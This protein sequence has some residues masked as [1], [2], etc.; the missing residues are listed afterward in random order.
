MRCNHAVAISDAKDISHQWHRVETLCAR[1]DISKKST[2]STSTDFQLNTSLLP[3]RSLRHRVRPPSTTH[4]RSVHRAFQATTTTI[5]ALSAETVPCRTQGVST[6][7]QRWLP[8]W[9]AFDGFERLECKRNATHPSTQQWFALR[10]DTFACVS[11]KRE[12]ASQ[13]GDGDCA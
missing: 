11:F 9:N 8:Q 5:R 10:K 1:H 4:P 13:Q 2:A 6:T 12:R 7:R 3:R